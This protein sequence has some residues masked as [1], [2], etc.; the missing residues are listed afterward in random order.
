MT[1]THW[2]FPLPC[3][4]AACLAASAQ[5]Y[6]PPDAKTPDK[7]TQDAIVAKTQQL[8]QMLATMQRQGVR[9]PVFA[10][11]EIYHKAAT[12]IVRHNEFYSDQFRAWT[13]AVLDRA[14]CCGPASA[15]A[16]SRRG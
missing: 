14:A 9:D 11:V 4:L 2:F 13:V 7:A 10:D 16:T 12:W 5:S 6:D 15:H 3:L 8:G 1:R